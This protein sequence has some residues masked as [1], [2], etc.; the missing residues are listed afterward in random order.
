MTDKR[1]TEI[2]DLELIGFECEFL[3]C[4]ECRFKGVCTE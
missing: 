2:E 1:L 4:D 3:V